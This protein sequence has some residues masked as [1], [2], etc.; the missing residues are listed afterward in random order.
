MD[1][2]AS[3]MMPSPESLD[4]ASARVRNRIETKQ[5]ADE[6]QLRDQYAG[7]GRSNSGGYEAARERNRAYAQSAY[8]TGLAEVEDAYERNRM[9]GAKNLGELGTNYGDLVL[10]ENKIDLDRGPLDLDRTTESNK[11]LTD[12]RNSVIDFFNGMGAYGNTDANP[13]F[14]NQFSTLKESIYRMFGVDPGQ[15]FGPN[16]VAPPTGTAPTGGTGPGPAWGPYAGQPL[17]SPHSVPGV[18]PTPPF[19][20]WTWGWNAQG[21]PSWL[22]P[23]GA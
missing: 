17:P 15:M 3:N 22:P 10:G 16:P 20:G 21:R 11:H 4:R 23:G 13:N 14:T 5:R 7:T 12:T 8:G 2:A 1:E 9:A 19:P 18:S 6:T